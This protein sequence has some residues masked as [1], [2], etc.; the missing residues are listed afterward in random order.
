MWSGCELGCRPLSD[1]GCR[2]R[3]SVAYNIRDFMSAMCLRQRLLVT[4]MVSLV[5]LGGILYGYDI[6]VIS[7][8]MGLIDTYFK[9]HGHSLTNMQQGVIYGAVLAGG[10]LGTLIAGPMAD[11][12]GRRI[13]II[14]ACLNFMLGIGLITA[15]TTFMSLLA[16]RLVLGIAVGIVAVAIPLYVAELVSAEQRGK[17]VAFFQ[18]FLTS[19][20]LLA[21]VVDLGLVAGGHWRMMF[22]VV[23]I[24]TCI[25]FLAMCFLPESPRWLWEQGK[26]ALARTVLLK[27]HTTAQTETAL[28]EFAEQAA[29]DQGSWRELFTGST[30]FVLILAVAIAILNQWTGINTFLQYAPSLLKSSGVNSSMQTAVGIPLLNLIC[31]LLAL[32]LVDKIG[33]RVLL[34]VGVGGVFLAELFLGMVPYISTHMVASSNLM[35]Y[36]FYAFISFFAIGPGVVIWL[37]VSELFPTRLRGKGIALCLFFNSLAGT[38]LSTL[39]LSIQ[40]WLGVSGSYWLCAMFSLAYFVIVYC[41]LPETKGVSLEQIQHF[42]SMKGRGKT[43]TLKEVDEALV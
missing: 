35:L 11:R 39:F 21:Y 18:L 6:G 2:F 32:F 23:L 8:A 43:I 31:T 33:R 25:L 16:A 42:F 26:S 41:Y 9:Q 29:A 34:L 3:M 13:A 36:G 38:I 7:G 27:T 40:S 37:V 10:L 17:Y 28:A 12:Y 4:L 30:G 19:G 22:A 1:Q 5:G 15:A 20:I 24:P 14:F